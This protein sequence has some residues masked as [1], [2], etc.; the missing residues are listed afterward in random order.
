MITEFPFCQDIREIQSLKPAG[1]IQPWPC[2]HGWFEGPEDH[3]TP[4]GD[5]EP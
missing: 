2:I 3:W 4:E 5:M 1:K